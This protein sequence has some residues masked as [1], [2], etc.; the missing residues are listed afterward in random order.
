[1]AAPR[2]LREDWMDK[3]LLWLIKERP[4]LVPAVFMQLASRLK[5]DQFAA[6]MTE[7][8]LMD[9]FRVILSSPKGAFLRALFG[10]SSWK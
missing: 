4:D 6:F 2:S 3:K 10:G 1:M 8:T 7:N 9:A 5:G